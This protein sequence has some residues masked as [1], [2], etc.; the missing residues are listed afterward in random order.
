M[1]DVTLEIEGLNLERLLRTASTAGFVLEDVQRE[2]VRSVRVRLPVWERKR[3]LAL[4][5]RYGWQ[6]REIQAAMPVKAM[7]FAA[8]RLMLGAGMMLF[9]LLMY[10]SSRMV[11]AVTVEN[12]GENVAEVHRFLEEQ[13][14][15]P[16]RLKAAFS[17]DVLREGLTLRL[18]GLSHVAVRYDGSTLV[19]SCQGAREGEKTDIPGEASDIVALQPGIVTRITVRSGTPAV[20]VGQAVRKGQVLIRGE[21]RAEGGTVRR[22]Q[23]QGEVLARVYAQGEAR[24]SLMQQRTVE[25]GRTQT[26]VTI[27]SPWHTRVVKDAAGFESQDVSV[28]RQDVVGLY[29]PLWRRIE[30]FAETVILSERR[31]RTDAASQAQGA[32]E[33]IAK[34]NCPSGVEILDKWVDY[35]MIDDE[36]VYATVV[37]EYEAG[38]AGRISP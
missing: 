17:T 14:V 22:V 9:V 28:E 7:R 6:A 35:S 18:P 27:E 38:I 25:T 34:L 11:W 8:R 30:T 4:C 19:V 3:M 16:G 15:R 32:A 26:R 31:S 36:F 21:E 12:A 23:A 1:L 33:K 5:E 24:V 10:G 20:E 37:L 29:L 13:G 2:D